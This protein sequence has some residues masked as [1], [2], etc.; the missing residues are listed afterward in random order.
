MYLISF[1]LDVNYRR[2]IA[3]IIHQQ[4]C[5]YKVKAIFSGIWSRVGIFRTDVSGERVASIFRVDRISKMKM[6]A[7]RS[8]ETSVLRRPTWLH[9]REDG[10]LY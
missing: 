7:T 10:I 3:R 9:I 6:E 8:F 5:G 4:L 2:C 1:I